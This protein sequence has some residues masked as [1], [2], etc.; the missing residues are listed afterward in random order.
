MMQTILI[1]A[2]DDYYGKAKW[3]LDL[4]ESIFLLP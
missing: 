4:W 1:N 3:D 2:I